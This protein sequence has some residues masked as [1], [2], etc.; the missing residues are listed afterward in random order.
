L[1]IEHRMS[2]REIVG[3][4]ADDAGTLVRGEIRLARAEFDQ[5]TNRLITGLVSLIGAMFLAYAGLIVLL[6]GVARALSL[7]I[8]LWAALLAIG[9]IVLAIG[10]LLALGA[11]KALAPSG[12]LPDRTAANLQADA[13]VVKEHAA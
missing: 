1:N 13:A 10:A 7:A 11:R 3:G 9:F 5:K 6:L 4:L 8:P 2:L 12:M